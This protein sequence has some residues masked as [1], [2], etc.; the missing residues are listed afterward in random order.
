MSNGHE[1]KTYWI[2]NHIWRWLRFEK[3]SVSTQLWKKIWLCQKRSDLSHFSMVM[4][5]KPRWNWWN[6]ARMKCEQDFIISFINLL[7]HLVNSAAYLDMLPSMDFSLFII[8]SFVPADTEEYVICIMVWYSC[9][10]FNSKHNTS[11]HLTVLYQ[12]ALCKIIIHE[13]LTWASVPKENKEKM[14]P[15]ASYKAIAV[16]TCAKQIFHYDLLLLNGPQNCVLV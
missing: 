2:G 3:I 15:D 10:L 8:H 11:M 7:I 4:W 5:M 9:C 1:S 16:G 14:N 12:A 13:Q 6:S